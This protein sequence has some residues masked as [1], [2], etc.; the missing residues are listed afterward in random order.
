MAARRGHIVNVVGDSLLAEFPSIVESLECAVEIQRS[1]AERNQDTPRERRLCSRIGINFGGVVVEADEMFGDGVNITARLEVLAEP[2]GI[3]VSG[4]VFSE[5][6]NKLK[7]GF[8]SLGE[9]RLK[10]I[11]D[12]VHVYRLCVEQG[13]SSASSASDWPNAPRTIPG[14]V[15]VATMDRSA[16]PSARGKG[17]SRGDGRGRAARMSMCSRIAANTLG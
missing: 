3:C 16:V 4:A 1:L 5:V 14:R 7:L 10:N 2:G 8:E 9:R 6:K 11:P 17:S 12:L 15:W 13:P